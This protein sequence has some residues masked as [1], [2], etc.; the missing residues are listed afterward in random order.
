[1]S[2]RILIVGNS[3]SGKS[4]LATRIAGDLA[5]PHLDL[6]S[7]V[8]EPGLVAVQR[9]F[10]VTCGLLASFAEGERVWVVEGCYGELIER[11]LPFCT[12]LLFLNPGLET[13]LRNNQARPWEPHKYESPEAQDAMLA[14][15]Q[16]WVAGYYER[17][18]AWS[19]VA[20][21]KLFENF[22]GL[23]REFQASA[24]NGA[25]MRTTGRESDVS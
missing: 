23:K 14:N 2:H 16:Q 1:M 9:P 7:I 22:N 8:W 13:C 25:F 6:D 18:D 10:E 19:Y 21:R 3:G 20:H 24:A 17:A 4:T 11:A 5:C 15:L 12:E